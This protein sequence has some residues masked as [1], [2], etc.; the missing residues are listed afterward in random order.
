VIMKILCQL[1][2]NVV[3]VILHVNSKSLLNKNDIELTKSKD[4][5]FTLKVQFENRTLVYNLRRKHTNV[6]TLIAEED[7]SLS[8]L[9]KHTEFLY[10]DPDQETS[11]VLEKDDTSSRYL[12]SGVLGPELIIL[13]KISD[14]DTKVHSSRCSHCLDVMSHSVVR[15]WT[16]DSLD[17]AGDYAE[18]DVQTN[19]RISRR[20]KALSR[21]GKVYPEILVLVDYTL[22]R[23]FGF[24]VAEARKYVI[25]YFNAVNMR[26][27]TFTQPRIELQIAGVI[28]GKSKSS[29]SFIS[30][31]IRYGDMLDAPATLNAMGQYYY[32]DRSNLPVYDMV[33]TL[34]GLD[35]ARMKNGKMS[36][37]NT[38]YAYIGGACIRNA[39]LKKISSVALVEDSGGYS[40]VV[41][42]AHE[43]G[44]LLGAVHDGDKSPSYLRGPGAKSC[45]WSAGYIMSDLRHT[46]RGQQWSD[47][48]VKQIK[49][50]LKT[51]AAQCLYNPPPRN[52]DYSLPGDNKLPGSSIS[53]DDQCRKDK[54]TRACYH[55]DRVCAQLFCYTKNYSGCYAYR[56][57][58]EG[59]YC[60]KGK[61]CINGKCVKKSHQDKT[62]V[63]YTSRRPKV[64]K[65]QQLK[66]KSPKPKTRNVGKTK[67]ISRQQRGK[68]SA[69][70]KVGK[71]SLPRTSKSSKDVA[72]GDSDCSDSFALMGSLNC[73]QLFKRYAFN[74]CNRSK[75]VRKK[76]CKSY[77]KYCGS[78]SSVA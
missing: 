35:M 43:I 21:S 68:S 77:N 61:M 7:E 9:E 47:C 73:E 26:F 22:F 13:P 74:Y 18:A 64:A 23:K 38:G 8:P 51:S 40:G 56:P 19:Y 33:V 5:F 15:R 12:I 17:G 4:N 54:G 27:K 36:R 20:G 53:L 65:L 71:Y 1:I 37:S 55:D 59:S 6:N 39:Y 34:T 48:S 32:K 11:V 10:E 16:N 42:T 29:F 60:G 44:H 67:P 30:S 14:N 41:V 62:P 50:F 57:A 75:V 72:G 24:N 76:C 31:S 28:F 69:K 78:S 46:S 25:S 58:V 2:I 52:N 66:K 45:P 70:S 63:K 49:Y 3:T